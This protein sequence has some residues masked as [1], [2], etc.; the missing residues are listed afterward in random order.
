MPHARALAAVLATGLLLAGC[1]SGSDDS[2]DAARVVQLG[3]PGEAPEELA[4]SDVPSA[5]APPYSEADVAFVQGMIHHHAQGL[6]MTALVPDRSA[7]A[8]RTVMS[9]RRDERL[10]G[11]LCRK[12][13]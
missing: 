11:N 12:L 1:T 8:A 10:V 9:G 5:E 4:S 13:G 6:E 2:D 3:A 7:M